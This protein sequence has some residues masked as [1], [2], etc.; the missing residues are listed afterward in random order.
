MLFCYVASSVKDL[1]ANEDFSE[2]NETLLTDLMYGEYLTII[3]RRRGDYRGIFAETNS[4]C[5]SIFA[6]VFLCFSGLNSF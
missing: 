6:Q 2:I 5:F 3:R 1:H 4:R